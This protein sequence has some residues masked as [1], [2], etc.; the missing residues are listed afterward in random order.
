[1]N[2]RS[3]LPHWALAFVTPI[4]SFLVACSPSTDEPMTIMVNGKISEVRGCAPPDEKNRTSCLR[5][6]C[7]KVL[8]ERAVLPPYAQV[9]K[10]HSIV[11]RSDLPRRTE[12]TLKFQHNNQVRFAKCEM[13]DLVVVTAHE[14]SAQGQDW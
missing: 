11:N 9:K 5:V 12:H 4:V 8:Y 7:E 6:L 10:S 14:V 1:M 3:P 2:A 13:D